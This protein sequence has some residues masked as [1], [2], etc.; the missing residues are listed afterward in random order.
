MVI[1]C[2]QVWQDIS[3][4]LEGEVNPDLRAAMEAHFRDCKRCTAVLDGAR[5]VIQ[6]YG[7]DRS[8]EL[9]AG[10][11]AGWQ[12][13]LAEHMPNL[14]GASPRGTAFGWLLAAAA[15]ALISGSFAL[16]RLD[17]GSVSGL[18]SYHAE[19]GT[20]VPDEMMVAVSADGKTF[21]VPG[22]RFLHKHENENVRLIAASEAIRQGYVPCV[23]CLRQY[24]NR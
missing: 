11:T 24:L 17:A 10:F 18:R 6:L 20:G 14:R 21:H 9:P 13:R 8:L 23:R 7:D 19:P 12:S 3:N 15:A 22:C 5:N 1:N 2:E 4:Y 16:A